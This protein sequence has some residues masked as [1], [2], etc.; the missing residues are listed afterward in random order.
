MSQF[1]FHEWRG[2]GREVPLI[3]QPYLLPAVAVGGGGPTTLPA[4]CAA[5]SAPTNVWQGGYQAT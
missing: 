4:A 5:S 2:W 1:G 3:L